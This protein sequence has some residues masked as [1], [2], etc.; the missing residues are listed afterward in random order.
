M[1]Q[2]IAHW[3]ER[4]VFSFDFEMKRERQSHNLGGVVQEKDI[5]KP[6]FEVI[7]ALAIDTAELE[8]SEIR[9]C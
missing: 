4:H 6:F 1:R 8:H 3:K 5:N 7:F 2:Y 9:S